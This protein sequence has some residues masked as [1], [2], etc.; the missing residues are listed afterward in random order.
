VSGR[1]LA[2]AFVSELLLLV[3]PSR[4]LMGRVLRNFEWCLHPS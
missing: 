4:R 1:E 3:L 2:S